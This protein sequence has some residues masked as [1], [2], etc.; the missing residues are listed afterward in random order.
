MTRNPRRLPVFR[1]F[2]AVAAVLVLGACGSVREAVGI[3]ADS[4]DEYQVVVR[5]PLSMPQDYGLKAPR[6]GTEGP[7]EGRLRDRTRQIVLDSQ[8]KEKAAQAN[9]PIE[10][11][12]RAESVLLSKLGANDVDPNIRQVV[13]RE[14]TAVELENRSMIDRILFWR[15]APPESKTVD[16]QAE[17]RRLQENAALGRAPVAG[18]TPEIERKKSRSLLDRLF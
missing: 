3:D 5:A 10:G 18:E 14:T 15:E 13:E 4:P 6:P 16:A 1:L 17:R 11:V 9:R 8:G 12:T 7:Q 2:T